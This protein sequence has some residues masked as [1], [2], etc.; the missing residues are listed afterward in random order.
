MSKTTCVY[1]ECT[2]EQERTFWCNKHWGLFPHKCVTPGCDRTVQ[3]DDEPWCFT[4]S[5]DEGSSQR[6]YSAYIAS[7]DSHISTF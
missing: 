5:P 7:K 1:P 4:H 2:H 6:G 3:Y